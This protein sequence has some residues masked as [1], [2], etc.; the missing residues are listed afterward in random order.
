MQNKLYLTRLHNN[1]KIYIK[2]QL[3]PL[4]WKALYQ[5]VDNISLGIFIKST[6]LKDI[7]NN[8]MIDAANQFLIYSSNEATL[9]IRMKQRALFLQGLYNYEKISGI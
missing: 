8:L 1:I 6:L 5:L 4:Q 3:Q 9:Q 2:T 7:N